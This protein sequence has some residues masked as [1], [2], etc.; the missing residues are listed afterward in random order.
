MI[1]R[2]NI[3]NAIDAIIKAIELDEENVEY[4]QL[5][6]ALYERK[7]SL[8]NDKDMLYKLIDLARGGL[9]LPSAQDIPGP[10]QFEGRRNKIFLLSFL[11]NC[12]IDEALKALPKV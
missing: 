7:Y 4:I 2:D 6:M 9:N 8:Y 3:D 1:S 5:A 12:Y 10:R 11:S